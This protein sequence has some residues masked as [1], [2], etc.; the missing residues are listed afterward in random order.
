[1]PVSL[2]ASQ[3]TAPGVYVREIPAGATP[4][5][6]TFNRLYL[7]GTAA[8][9]AT[10]RLPLTPYQIASYD[11]FLNQFG[12]SSAV[13]LNTIEYLFKFYPNAQVFYA[14]VEKAEQRTITVVQPVTA[15]AHTLTFDIGG[16]PTAVTYT[17]V[18]T[19][20]AQ[21]VIDALLAAV[22][23][24][25][26]LNQL[27]EIETAINNDGESDYTAGEFYVRAKL[28]NKA[29][30]SLT[31]SAKLALSPLSP[32]AAPTA[33]DWTYG[34]TASFGEDLPQGYLCIPEPF[35]T[36]PRQADRTAVQ[37][38]IEL[39]TSD[40]AINWIGIVDSGPP[41]LIDDS[42]AMEA[43]RLNYT[44]TRG[45]TWYIGPW[46]KDSDNDYVSPAAMQAVFALKRNSIESFVQPPAG[47][48]Y[49]LVG[50]RDLDFNVTTNQHATLNQA[51]VNVIKPIRGK[52]LCVYG[53]RTMSIDPLYRFCNTRVILNVYAR[54]LY[55][56][57]ANSN[58]V[59]TVIDGEGTLFNRVK[60]VADTLCFRLLEAGALYGASPDDAFLNICDARNNPDLDLQGGAVQL[61]SILTISPTGERIIANIAPIPIGA[62][63]AY[64]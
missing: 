11:D 58:L 55:D 45:H 14:A 32:A 36:M 22:N 48:G 8:A 29:L 21:I 31:S 61:T 20:T 1:M 17:A 10:D 38:A 40:Q 50:L 62:L 60:Q 64:A 28:P 5:I 39:F 15:G 9:L 19:D 13:I 12:G 27:V 56:S 59:F 4:E 3:L 43:E 30:P 2:A 34:I 41:A 49:P 33:T 54:S 23:D 24:N 35:Y 26:A 51:G 46:P 18:G 25:T 16:T 52:G 6:T 44:S 47:T 53:A 57:L 42:S 7:L 63:A 37:Q